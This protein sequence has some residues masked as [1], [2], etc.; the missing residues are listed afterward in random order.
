MHHTTNI[1]TEWGPTI[2]YSRLCGL[3]EAMDGATTA[4]SSA[5]ADWMA[6]KPPTSDRVAE[7]Q[8][9]LAAVDQ[10]RTAHHEAKAW[11]E[12]PVALEG[13]MAWVDGPS[14]DT[15]SSTLVGIEEAMG[16]CNAAMDDLRADRCAQAA[17]RGING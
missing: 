10:A 11:A 3:V 2:A 9:A 6:G 8:A 7:I 15:L 17:L 12:R 5:V 1:E 13:A 4:M 14:A 16:Q